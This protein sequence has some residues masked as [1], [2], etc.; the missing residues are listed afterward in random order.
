MEKTILSSEQIQ[1]LIAR[2][3]E[4]REKAYSPY[5]SF[6]V[7]SAILAESGK[8]YTGA[9]IENASSGATICA[10]R[11][12]ATHAASEGERKFLAVAIVGWKKDATLEER[13]LAYPC[14]ICR[15][16]LNEFSEPDLPIYIA[17]TTDDYFATTLGDL[18]PCSFGPEHL[19]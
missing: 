6:Q 5:S 14:G 15:Q 13:D 17:R 3:I 9:N 10:E 4:A 12:A 7:G 16:F 11:S 2:A 19:A 18:L 8:I 1:D